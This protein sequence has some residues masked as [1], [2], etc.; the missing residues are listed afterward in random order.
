MLTSRQMCRRVDGAERATWQV[1][2]FLRKLG[3]V[4]EADLVV[5]L[6]VMG[7]SVE[8]LVFAELHGFLGADADKAR[9]FDAGQTVAPHHLENLIVNNCDSCEA[10]NAPA[11]RNIML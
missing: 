7:V 2:E 11:I 5:K 6:L 4:A 8:M 10:R 9:R 3:L 1:Q